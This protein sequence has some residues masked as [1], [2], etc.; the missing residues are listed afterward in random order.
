MKKIL[1]FIL[2]LNILITILPV[3][4]S[5]DSFQ[6]ST[7]ASDKEWKLLSL[8]NDYRVTKGKTPVTVL[9]NIQSASDTRA[10]E[11]LSGLSHYRP[12]GEMWYT[13]LGE[14]SLSYDSKSFE[15][16]AANFNKAEDVFKA[17]ITSES[18]MRKL[19]GD[20]DHLGIG[21]SESTNSANK[22]TWAVIGIKCSGV[23]SLSLY[24]ADG[25]HSDW[26][27]GEACFKDIVVGTGCS[28]G[29]SY[30]PIHISMTEG[31]DRNVVGKITVRVNYKGLWASFEMTNDYT[32]VKQNQWFYDSVMACS[33]NKYFSGVG[34][35]A[36]A[37]NDSMTR[38]MFVTVLGRFQGVDTAKYTGTSFLDVKTGQ[39][40]SPYVEWAAQNDI[41]TGD[42]GGRFNG[43][44]GITRQELCVMIMRYIENSNIDLD[45]VNSD[46]TF[47]DHSDIAL[48]A[49]DAVVYCRR[50]GIIEGDTLGNFNPGQVATRAQVATVIKNIHNMIK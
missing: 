10:D 2:I 37:P 19:L 6:Y 41:V 9:S 20:V 36:F 23:E 28:H 3:A 30:A 12:N 27:I 29:K 34:N 13:V 25:L 4:V 8:I 50:R 39:W 16:I 5:A 31:Y 18:N 48:W 49:R 22:N 14:Y 35:G 44:R 24:N 46:K 17:L 45:T 1:S 38:E 7:M 32:D 15:C 11:L 26:M 21:Y 42:G 47:T 43:A 33:E 40:Y